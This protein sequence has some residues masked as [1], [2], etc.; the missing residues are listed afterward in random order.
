MSA[1][2]VRT[3]PGKDWRR[4]VDEHPQGNIFH[5]PEMFQVF[6][7][8]QGHHPTLWA[9][10]GHHGRILALLL[11]VQ[12]T[13]INGPLR[14]FTTRAVAYGGVLCAPGSAGREGLAALLR[15]YTRQRKGRPLFTE[16]R[17][18]SEPDDLQAILQD[19][20]FVYED[21]LNF[22]IDISLPVEQVWGNIRKSARKSI[23]K[24]LNKDELVIT[25]VDALSQ[26]ATCY[27]IFQKTYAQADV[28]LADRSLFEAAFEVLHPKGMAQFLLGRIEET[29]VAAAVALLYKDRIHGWYRGF[30]R[31][32]SSYLPNDLMV[33]HVLKWGTENGY[34]VFDFGGAGKPDEEY[35]PRR[36]KAKFGP[37]LVCYGRNTHV[38][39]PTRLA[40]SKRGYQV[41]QRFIGSRDRPMAGDR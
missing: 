27:D 14:G 5:T 13:L 15:A 20:D 1:R 19:H 6:S 25:E 12:I 30:D 40:I 17:H 3:L 7:R 2:I 28:P 21:H 11:P 23:R 37:E 38:H 10:V 34:R 32:Y 36:F 35:G 18:T 22:L 41:Y 4:F 24:A 33:W 31:A 16:L 9:A 39:A 8:A 29:D 26:V